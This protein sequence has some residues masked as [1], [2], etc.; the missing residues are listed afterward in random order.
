MAKVVSIIIGWNASTTLTSAAVHQQSLDIPHPEEQL[1]EGQTACPKQESFNVSPEQEQLFLEDSQWL[2]MKCPNK[3]AGMK[4]NKLG[5]KH[6][7]CVQGSLSSN[8]LTPC[9]RPSQLNSRG[10]HFFH[11]YTISL[12]STYA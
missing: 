5:L 9:L 11:F 2:K 1:Q 3:I 4:A 6:S 12:Y 10:I 7:T 8:E